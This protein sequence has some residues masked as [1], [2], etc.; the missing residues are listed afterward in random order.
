MNCEEE[1]CQSHCEANI[2]QV[3]TSEEI[4]LGGYL[5]EW[6]WGTKKF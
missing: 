2:E 5:P 3:A 6:D 1:A 4:I